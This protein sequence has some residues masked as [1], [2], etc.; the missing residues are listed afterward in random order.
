MRGVWAVWQFFK[1]TSPIKSW[2]RHC[3]R[4]T[5]QVD[6]FGGHQTRVAG[7]MKLE[8]VL[9]HR[10]HIH[11]KGLCELSF[12]KTPSYQATNNLVHAN[13]TAFCVAGSP[14]PGVLTLLS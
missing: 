2:I 6:M 11:M 10:D 14:P 8:H 4:D 12:N 7:L 13:S 9:S 5:N 3:V 1:S